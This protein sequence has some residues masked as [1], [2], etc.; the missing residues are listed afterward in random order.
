MHRDRRAVHLFVEDDLAAEVFDGVTGV[1]IE[2][3][4]VDVSRMRLDSTHIL[5]DMATLGRTKLMGVSIKRFLTQLNRHHRDLYE[6]LDETCG[7]DNDVQLITAAFPEPADRQ[8][9]DALTID[10]F[11][12][13]EASETVEHC[14]NGCE[15]L[16]SKH[17]PATGVTPTRMDPAD[18]RVCEFFS[19]C[20]VKKAHTRFVLRHTGQATPACGAA[21]R[22][23]H[24]RLLGQLRDPQRRRERQQR[25]Q[26]QDGHGAS[27]GAGLSTRS[28]GGAASVCRLEPVPRRPCAPKAWEMRLCGPPGPISASRTRS[29]GRRAPREAPDEPHHAHRSPVSRP[30]LCFRR[31]KPAVLREASFQVFLSFFRVLPSRRTR[32]QR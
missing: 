31:L 25:V 8:A 20:P 1:L 16:S 6:Q 18:C 9:A 13:D 7:Q 22:A 5:S 19:A 21:G 23:G 10:D 17:D 29:M 24:G 2:A 15:P 26:A 3:L 27:S 11:V 4:E 28:H 32:G 30:P 12:V 14:L